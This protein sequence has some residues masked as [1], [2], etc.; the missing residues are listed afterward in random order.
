MKSVCVFCGS[1]SGAHPAYAEVARAMGEE[2]ARRGLTLVYGGGHVGLM[3][4]VADAALSAGGD[5]VGIIPQALVDRELAHPRLTRLHIVGSMHERKAMMESLSDG[6]VAMPGGFGTLEEFC[7]IVTWAQLGL[8]GKP[9]GLLDVAGYYNT[10][11]RFLDEN[12]EQGFVNPTHRQMILVES[13]P[14]R[15]LD[16]MDRYD[17]PQVIKWVTIRES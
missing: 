11:I 12:V 9:C 6:F 15:M 4:H 2:I 5:V 8:H 3:G 14:A 10:L 17:P 13:D 7:E 1:R 16:A